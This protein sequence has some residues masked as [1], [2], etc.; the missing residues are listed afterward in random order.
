LDLVKSYPITSRKALNN[1]ELLEKEMHNRM[2]F[3]D[4][5]NGLLKINP[6]ERWTPKQAR[7][8]PFISGERWSGP[9]IPPMPFSNHEVEKKQSTVSTEPPS[10]SGSSPSS[11]KKPH[12]GEPRFQRPRAYTISSLGPHNVP[13]QLQELSVASGLQKQQQP[14]NLPS[15]QSA[16]AYD[17]AQQYQRHEMQQQGNRAAL[18]SPLD[19]N[20]PNFPPLPDY[21]NTVSSEDTAKIDNRKKTGFYQNFSKSRPYKGTPQ[22]TVNSPLSKDPGGSISEVPVNIGRRMSYDSSPAS[23]SARPPQRRAS[24]LTTSLSQLQSHY[25]VDP[26]LGKRYGGSVPN[27]NKPYVHDDYNIGVCYLI[28]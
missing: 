8:H 5:V 1:K 24:L 12:P 22:K 19:P 13:H 27:I 17:T 25:S 3:I 15:Q 6:L 4:F 18:H 21:A 2:C 28:M 9:F 14:Q 16:Y 26:P 7:L 10:E 11:S 23:S 20:P